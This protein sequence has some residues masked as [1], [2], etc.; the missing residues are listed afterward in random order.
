LHSSVTARR[1]KSQEFHGRIPAPQEFSSKSQVPNHPSDPLRATA[2]P[3]RATGTNKQ[4]R[5]SRTAMQTQGSTRGGPL[6]NP[7]PPSGPC[8]SA[9]RPPKDLSERGGPRPPPSRS[10]SSPTTARALPAAGVGGAVPA[11]RSWHGTRHAGIFHSAAGKMNVPGSGVRTGANKAG[12]H[13][14]GA[15]QSPPPAAFWQSVHKHGPQAQSAAQPAP[16]AS[17]LASPPPL[18]PSAQNPGQ[19][20][21]SWK[22]LPRIAAAGRDLEPGRSD[23]V[24]RRAAA[25]CHPLEPRGTPRR[26][27]MRVPPSWRS[28]HLLNM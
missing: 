23:G 3:L 27:A 25:R 20:S 11:H 17:P 8:A 9:P 22:R 2:P 19:P 24:Q 15:S 21:P 18:A 5:P 1:A 6:P 28:I 16:L 7:R 10:P 14:H 26:S 12:S 4:Q 13:A